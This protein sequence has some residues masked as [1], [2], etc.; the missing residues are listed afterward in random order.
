MQSFVS[1]ESFV[2][3]VCL[4]ADAAAADGGGGSSFGI[5]PVLFII[6]ALF[7]IMVVLPQRKKEK[8]RRTLL[9]N[10][11]KNDRV[12]TVGGVYGVVTNVQS[13]VGR[14]TLRVDESTGATVRFR[15][16]AID[17]VLAD[18]D[19]ADAERSKA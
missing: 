7:Y 1:T 17:T 5:W 13:E 9:D 12:V 18:D 6:L 4:L 10:L 19:K 3:T 14:V 11:K 2:S 15:T 16:T 8:D